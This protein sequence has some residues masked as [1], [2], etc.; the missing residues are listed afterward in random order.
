MSQFHFTFE[1]IQHQYK[2]AI[3]SGY[4]IITCDE[5]FKLKNE[6]KIPDK[7]IVNRID[8]DFSVKKAETLGQIFKSLSIKGTFFIRLHAAE[9]NPFSIENYKVIKELIASGNE[10]GYHSEITDESVIWNED[11]VSCL[12]KDI[13]IINKMFDTEIKGTASHGGMTGL[14]N[15]DFW[16]THTPSE[17]GLNYEAY[18]EDLFN[19]SFYISD[20]EWTRWKCY[21]KGKLIEGDNRSFGEHISDNHK[22]I[23]LLI[24]SD[25]YFKNHFYE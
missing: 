18:A 22:L 10:I 25:T 5:Y 1:N 21:D 4:K 15:L 13:C 12:K 16:K 20:S 11:A 8:I 19:N 7:C 2:T 23:Y 9:Y 24:H 17:F 14:N 3:D 6:N